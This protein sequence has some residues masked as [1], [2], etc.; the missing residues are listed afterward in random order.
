VTSDTDINGEITPDMIV[1]VEILLLE[2]GTWEVLSI[3]PLSDFTEIPGCLT[4]MATVSSVNGNEIQ[5]VGWPV[6]T[7]GE[8]VGIENEEG[9]AGTLSANQSVLV[10]VCA[11]EDGQVFIT[12]IILLNSSEGGEAEEGKKVLVCHKPDKKGGH[13]L[14]IAEP[15]APAHLAHGDKL[16]ACT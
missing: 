2:D 9:G 4:V 10:V 11:S 7:L 1:L 8:D 13:T 3:T 6:I 5:L 15:A 12:K 14:S 16:G